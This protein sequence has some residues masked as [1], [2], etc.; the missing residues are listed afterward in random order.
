MVVT[1]KISTNP[2][3]PLIIDC[4]L[5][6]LR[7]KGDRGLTMRQVALK[8]GISLSN[9]QFYFKN[10][11][12]LLKGMVDFYF[13]KCATLFDAHIESSKA[14]STPKKKVYNLI[15]FGLGQGEEI[16]EICK[17][18]RELW[19][20][21]TRNDEVNTH[22]EAYYK[23]Y[24]GKLSAIISP[25]TGGVEEVHK[26]VTLL[27]PYFEGYAITAPI[28]PI[29]KKYVVEMLSNIILSILGIKTDSQS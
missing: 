8:A 18:F 22:L 20:I 7:E 16:T 25:L 29:E 9:L 1:K 23:E 2:R 5:S 10:K 3:V 19:A 24:A 14:T 17:I 4:A 12:E 11:D 13:D 21:A 28:L 26:A 15:T 6:I 27:L